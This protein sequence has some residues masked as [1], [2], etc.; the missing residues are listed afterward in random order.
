M[1]P[2]AERRRLLASWGMAGFFSMTTSTV[3][4]LPCVPGSQSRD[5]VFGSRVSPASDLE[6]W[7]LAPVCPQARSLEDWSFEWMMDGLLKGW[8]S[9]SFLYW[10]ITGEIKNF[11][12]V[13]SQTDEVTLAAVQ[14]NREF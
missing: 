11:L 13:A 2:I 3:V 6:T 9:F 5:L 14:R 7:S 1:A 8:A 12:L 4:W 10:G